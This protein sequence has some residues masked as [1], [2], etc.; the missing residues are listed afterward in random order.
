LAEAASAGSAAVQAII[1]KSAMEV[2]LY[3]NSCSYVVFR[4]IY[5]RMRYLRG[6]KDAAKR[7]CYGL[8]AEVSKLKQA[9]QRLL[10]Q[11]ERSS[12]Q[13]IAVPSSTPIP[14]VQ[15][16]SQAATAESVAAAVFAATTAAEQQHEAVLSNM[17]SR[18]SACEA[19]VQARRATQLFL[20]VVL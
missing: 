19:V 3:V 4:I 15:S 16:S 14:A 6:E 18:L 8:K 1:V 13:M 10:Q 5:F 2:D 20:F 7:V 12:S 17:R 9:N 11:H